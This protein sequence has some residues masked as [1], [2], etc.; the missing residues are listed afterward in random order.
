VRM[1]TGAQLAGVCTHEQKE[2]V[3]TWIRCG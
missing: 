3:T 1:A 2:L